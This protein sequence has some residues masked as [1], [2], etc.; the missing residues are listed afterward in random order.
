M[1]SWERLSTCLLMGS[2]QRVPW[3]SLLVHVAFALPSKAVC[4]STR[5]FMHFYLSDSDSPF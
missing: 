4:V 2:S 3:F 1:I 5:E